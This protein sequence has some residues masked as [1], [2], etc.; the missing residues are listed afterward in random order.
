MDYQ[1]PVVSYV[2]AILV[3]LMS[4]LIGFVAGVLVMVS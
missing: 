2:P 1:R 4:L 3:V